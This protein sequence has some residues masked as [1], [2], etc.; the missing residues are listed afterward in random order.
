MNVSYLTIDEISH[1]FKVTRKTIERWIKKGLPTIKVSGS[2]R[3]NPNDLEKWIEGTN[4]DNP[5]K[6]M[7]WLER[8]LK[9]KIILDLHNEY[10]KKNLEDFDYFKLHY[11][12]DIYLKLKS[13]L[14][15]Q[16]YVINIRSLP[17][18]PLPEH[19]W[20]NID[21]T[22]NLKFNTS[23]HNLLKLIVVYSNF[24]LLE[25][26]FNTKVIGNTK[27]IILNPSEIIN[28]NISNEIFNN[29]F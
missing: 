2:I 10:E 24:S 6:R 14:I 19:F 27:L 15:N 17:N 13:D 8:E 4:S 11:P 26:P 12:H 29:E 9:E 23:Q 22:F 20:C 1:L 5:I 7:I 3:I 25:K 28:F 16:S 18:Y 21:E